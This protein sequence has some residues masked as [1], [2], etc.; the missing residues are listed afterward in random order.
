LSVPLLGEHVR[1]RRRSAVVLGFAGALLVI[2]PGS[3][4]VNPAV[5]LLLVSAACYALYQIA[6]RGI[7]AFDGAA[8][9][10]I[11]SVILGSLATSAILPFVFVPPR[12]PGDLALFASLGLIGGSGHYLVICAFQHAPTAVLGPLGYIELVGTTT[13][14]VLI[15]GNLPDRWTWVGAPA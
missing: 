1:W 7:A 9:G 5:P 15:C 3:G 12:N 8:T 13:L 6:T 14:G 11:Y 10:I 2:R 4:F